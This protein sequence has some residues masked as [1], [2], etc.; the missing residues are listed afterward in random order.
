MRVKIPA[1]IL[2]LDGRPDPHFRWMLSELLRKLDRLEED[3]ARVD[4]RMDQLALP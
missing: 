1:L 4:A 2:A 3:R